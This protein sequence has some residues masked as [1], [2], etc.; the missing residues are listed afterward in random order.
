M[1]FASL[2]ENKM[3][4]NFRQQLQ[5]KTWSSA[6]LYQPQEG[7][8]VV[9]TAVSPPANRS[10][11][12]WCSSSCRGI[13][14]WTA[15]L[16]HL[17]ERPC[18]V[19][20]TAASPPANRFMLHIEAAAIAEQQN[21]DCR[22]NSNYERERDVSGLQNSIFTRCVCS[23]YK[24]GN[25]RS[26]CSKV[27]NLC[28]WGQLGGICPCIASHWI[29]QVIRQIL[30]WA[31]AS[32]NGLHE[33][34]EGGGWSQV[35]EPVW[36]ISATRNNH[37]ILQNMKSVFLSHTNKHVHIKQL[38]KNAI[39]LPR[40]EHRFCNKTTNKLELVQ[41]VLFCLDLN[42]I[43]ILQ[44]LNQPQ[45]RTELQSKRRRRRRRQ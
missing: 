21:F 30:K 22:V 31:F 44:T 42:P 13:K 27:L 24:L 10:M 2:E 17:Q 8:R 14:P 36:S 15:E 41:N 32:D 12:H 9:R 33:E 43:Q 28:S 25:V 20:T 4:L 29:G 45:D 19:V 35:L 16:H 26:G 5:N 18:K 34:A 39:K 7:C 38:G 6:E 40:R 3:Q 11:L 37:N 23:T 1:E